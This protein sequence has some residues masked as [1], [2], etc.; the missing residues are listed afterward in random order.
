MLQ[1]G[2]SLTL[3]FA[4]GGLYHYLVCTIVFAL[5]NHTLPVCIDQPTPVTVLRC[6]FCQQLFSAYLLTYTQAPEYPAHVS[7]PRKLFV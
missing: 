2:T 1:V 6:L 7:H 4:Y 3:K 5:T